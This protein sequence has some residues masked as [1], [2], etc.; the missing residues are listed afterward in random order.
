MGVLFREGYINIIYPE[1]RFCANF[2][3]HAVGHEFMDQA[4]FVASLGYVG[5]L[6]SV[7]FG[8]GICTVL[9]VP[10]LQFLYEL[11]VEQMRLRG[12]TLGPLIVETF[13]VESKYCYAKADL[14]VAGG[15]GV[16]EYLYG[17]HDDFKAGRPLH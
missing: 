14:A 9:D 10:F 3:D 6:V 15:H 12:A 1:A 8:H 5:T 13:G 7:V 17:L 2:P 16:L 4:D 11:K